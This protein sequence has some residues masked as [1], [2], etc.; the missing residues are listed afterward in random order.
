[1]S[2]INFF[3]SADLFKN[4]VCVNKEDLSVAEVY[5]TILLMS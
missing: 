4:L 1:M 5:T 2:V 3:Q